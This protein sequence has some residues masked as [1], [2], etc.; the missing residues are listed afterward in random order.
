MPK[1]QKHLT[2]WWWLLGAVVIIVLYLGSILAIDQYID[3]CE[4][5]AP[6]V[7]LTLKQRQEP[8]FFYKASCPDCRKVYPY[9]YLMSLTH[10]ITMINL[11]NQQNWFYIQPYHLTRVPTMVYQGKDYTG[12]NVIKIWQLIH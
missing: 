1:Q 3:H 5:Q 11:D 8:I 7:Q 4:K 10:H 12:T 9:V 6:T 2:R